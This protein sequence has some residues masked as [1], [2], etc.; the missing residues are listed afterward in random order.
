MALEEWKSVGDFNKFVYGMKIFAVWHV[1]SNQI[2]I[3][4]EN[5]RNLP[6]F[7]D[8]NFIMKI[9]MLEPVFWE[10]LFVQRI[11]SN[12]LHIIIIGAWSMIVICRFVAFEPIGLCV[13]PCMLDTKPAISWIS[14]IVVIISARAKYAAV[15]KSKSVK[16][17]HMHMKMAWIIELH[18]QLAVT[19]ATPKEVRDKRIIHAIAL[20]KWLETMWKDNKWD[21]LKLNDW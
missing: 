14:R 20:N 16:H 21:L 8:N 10:A 17:M 9:G 3:E 11:G 18:L 7:L 5:E 4:H 19:C 1:T 6:I 12:H 2:H 13:C 15:G